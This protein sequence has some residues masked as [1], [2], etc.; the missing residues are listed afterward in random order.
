MN[1]KITILGSLNYALR[2]LGYLEPPLAVACIAQV[3][4]EKYDVTSIDSNSLIIGDIEEKEAV[5]KIVNEVEKTE[6]DILAISSWTGAM[7]FTAEFVKEF[8]KRNPE[9][10]IILG[11]PNATFVSGKTLNLVKEIDFLVRGEGQNTILELVDALF[12][13]KNVNNIKGISLRKNNKIINNPN[14]ELIKDINKLPLL[15]FSSF[16]DFKSDNFALM[17]SI[18]CTYNC[19]FCSCPGFWKKY[20]FYSVDYIIKQIKLLQRLFGDIKIDFWDSNITM[21]KPWGKSFCNHLIKDKMNLEWFSYSRIDNV[22]LEILNLMKKAGCRTLFF[23]IESL[24]PKTVEFYNKTKDGDKYIKNNLK[25]FEILNKTKIDTILSFVIGAPCETRKEMLAYLND[26][27]NIRTRFRNVFFEFSQL[28]P[29]LGSYLWDNHEMFKVSRK[30]TR[31][32]YFGTQLF[33]EKYEKFPWMV[34]QAYLYKNNNMGNN[35]YEDTLNE[36]Y[37]KFKEINKEFK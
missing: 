1:K 35:E 14:R 28:T 20:R 13:N 3:L 18:G 16:Q 21:N 9:V 37:R 26:I 22:D 11:G 29:E 10:K 17:N 4:Q 6:P 27:K 36:I 8:R 23:G 2:N 31:E 15:D 24:D 30:D 34:P 7:P 19:K 12:K 5:D 25:T 32:R 33:T